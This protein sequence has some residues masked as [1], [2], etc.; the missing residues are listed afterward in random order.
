MTT[1]QTQSPPSVRSANLAVE[2]ALGRPQHV[3]HPA[4]HER[5]E[6]VVQ[7]GPVLGP[8]QQQRVTFHESVRPRGSR[9]VEAEHSEP[10][11]LPVLDLD[12]VV[13]GVKG[14]TLC[15]VSVGGLLSGRLFR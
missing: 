7:V 10:C 13:D 14:R 9:C 12:S 8:V 3:Q 1:S 4:Q 5:L 15:G 2:R 6:V 11:L